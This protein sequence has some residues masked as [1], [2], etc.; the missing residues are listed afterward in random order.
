MHSKMLSRHPMLEPRAKHH[1]PSFRFL[2]PCDLKRPRHGHTT[3]LGS[4]KH[5]AAAYP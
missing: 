2:S 3:A 4:P 5:R 1:A